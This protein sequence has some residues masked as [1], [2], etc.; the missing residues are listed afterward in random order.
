[1]FIQGLKKTCFLSLG[2]TSNSFQLVLKAAFGKNQHVQSSTNDMLSWPNNTR[3]V[4]AYKIQSTY[5]PNESLK[6]FSSLL[7]ANGHNPVETVYYL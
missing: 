1:M 5:D 7:N 3:K 2:M 6:Y 4:P